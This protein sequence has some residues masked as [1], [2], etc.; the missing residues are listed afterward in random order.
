MAQ[1]TQRTCQSCGGPLSARNR[2]GYCRRTRACSAAYNAAY[3]AANLAKI[4]EQQSAYYAA[5]RAKIKERTAAHWAANR[6][7]I[8]LL[9]RLKGS[10]PASTCVGAG[11]PAYAG[12]RECFCRVCGVSL[13]WRIPSRIKPSGTFC[14]RHRHSWRQL[15]VITTQ[16]ATDR[17]RAARRSVG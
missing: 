3:R 5:N 7:K 16:A 15:H 12:G 4:K 13:G 14:R 17:D 11:N 9:R 8:T 1:Q 10:V 6:E 2:V